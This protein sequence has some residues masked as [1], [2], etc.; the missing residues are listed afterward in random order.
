M[1]P[2]SEGNAGWRL[3]YASDPSNMTNYDFDPGHP[4][5]LITTQPTTVEELRRVVDNMALSGADTLIQ[6]VYNAAWTMFSAPSGSSTT[7][8]RSTAASSRCWMRGSCR[9]R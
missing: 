7:P 9:C 5:P 3:I 2:N 6:E 1:A 4:R 8:D